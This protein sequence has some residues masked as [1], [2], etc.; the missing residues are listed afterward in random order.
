M[1][2]SPHLFHAACMPFPAEQGPLA[3]ALLRRALRHLSGY[4]ISPESL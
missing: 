4:P 3:L 1:A 2:E